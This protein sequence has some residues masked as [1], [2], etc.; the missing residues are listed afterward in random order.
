MYALPHTHTHTHT[1]RT[2]AQ[3]TTTATVKPK[4][5]TAAATTNAKSNQK[6]QRKD[7]KCTEQRPSERTFHTFTGK[8][9]FSYFKYV[10]PQKAKVDNNGKKQSGKRKKRPKGIRSK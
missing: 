6:V 4:A 7:C 9:M 3:T 8:Y 10:P 1:H 2:E 5:S